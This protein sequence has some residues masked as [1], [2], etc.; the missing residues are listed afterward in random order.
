M[1]ILPKGGVMDL[2][3]AKIR[4]QINLYGFNDPTTYLKSVYQASK[5]LRK[6]Y[7]LMDFSEDLGFGRNNTMAQINNGHRPL[8]IKALERISTI[9][10]LDKAE[11][12]YLRA[13]LDLKTAKSSAY[14]EEK[15][16]LLLELQGRAKSDEPKDSP[17]NFF[18]SWHHAVVFELLDLSDPLEVAAIKNKF[19]M[20]ISD[21]DIENSLKL[22]QSLGLVRLV[23]GAQSKRYVK[24]Q[25]D[26][27]LGSA[28]PG[29]AIVRFHQEMMNLAK[30][31]LVSTPPQLRDISS[32]TISV[33]EETMQRMK[34]DVELFRRYLL[35]QASQCQNEDLVMQVNVQLFPLSKQ[36]PKE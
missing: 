20:E 9:L 30:E 11:K 26:F 27:S 2:A 14:K 10:K 23:E 29:N 24:T 19:S 31:S 32:V 4:K 13:T 12:A 15:L 18:N 34:K 7:T 16:A 5:S 25:K 8:T 3:L 35:F 33:D 21:T 6:S 1:P 28:I 17:L 36:E 22:L